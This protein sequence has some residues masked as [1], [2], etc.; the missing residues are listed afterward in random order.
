M[1][2]RRNYTHIEYNYNYLQAAT[3]YSPSGEIYFQSFFLCLV[4]KVTE[5]YSFIP[6]IE[7]S[8]HFQDSVVPSIYVRFLHTEILPDPFLPISVDGGDFKRNKLS[9]I[10]PSVRK[11]FHK[12]P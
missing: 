8:I 2:P 4:T 5:R 6:V 3:N 1:N 7:L 12:G 10:S 9:S 11:H